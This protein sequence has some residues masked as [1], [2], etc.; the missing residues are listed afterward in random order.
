[1]LNGRGMLS[2][3]ITVY[4]F[5]CLRHSWVIEFEGEYNSVADEL[6]PKVCMGI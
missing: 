4:M 1:M 5:C 2:N 6:L 3:A